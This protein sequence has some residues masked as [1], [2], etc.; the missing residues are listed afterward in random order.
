MLLFSCAGHGNPSSLHQE[1]RAASKALE[2]ARTTIAGLIGARPEGLYFTSGGTEAD[3]WAVHSAA[4][5]GVAR[6]KKHMI[7]SSIEHHAVLE[8]LFEH[9]KRGFEITLLKVSENG[10]VQPQEVESA[11]R[12]DTALVSVMFANNEIGTIQPISQIGAICQNR[13]VPFHTDAVQAV[14]HIPVDIDA[15]HIDMLSLSAH[16]FHGP[17]GVGALYCRPG[18]PL[19]PYILGGEQEQGKRAGTENICGIVGMAAALES[20]CS[21]MVESNRRVAAMRDKLIAS[22]EAIPGAS[23]TG[24]K[25]DRLPGNIHFCFEGIG[26]AG[27]LMV[28]D[29]HGIC[30]SSGAACASRRSE[31]SHVLKALG[32]PDRLARGALRLSLSCENTENEIDYLATKLPNLLKYMRD[33][34]SNY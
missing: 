30:A 17:G 11:I 21:G 22:L 14:G 33:M 24:G 19:A 27:L 1:G 18:V 23:L 32:T 15:L 26:S 28:L 5:A 29:M 20:C 25:S 8:P 7:A 4:A 31:P 9:K 34:G 2:K 13:G 6:G 12:P 16:K 3:N 10:S